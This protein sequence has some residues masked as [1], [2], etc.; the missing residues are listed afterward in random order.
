MQ[1][2]LAECEYD[3]SE[4]KLLNMQ[5]K[6]REFFEKLY[7]DSPNYPVLADILTQFT[8]KAVDPADILGSG[9]PTTGNT[10]Y[11]IKTECKEEIIKRSEEDVGVLFILGDMQFAVAE[12]SRKFPV[13]PRYYNMPRN[14]FLVPMMKLSL[15]LLFQDIQK[16]VFKLKRNLAI[17]E[18]LL[19][20]I[21]TV[22]NCIF[23]Y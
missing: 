18:D 5:K 2:F 15:Y 16:G 17:D 9:M 7:Y 12:L 22:I 1:D 19:N 6:H 21:D 10:Q 8:I 20:A 3:C 4:G 11:P 13:D 14:R 23:Y